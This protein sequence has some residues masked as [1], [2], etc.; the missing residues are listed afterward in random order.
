MH[1]INGHLEWTKG[2]LTFYKALPKEENEE[3]LAR[4]VKIEDYRRAFKT[5]D[6]S[7]ITPAQ[8]DQ[9]LLASPDE[10]ILREE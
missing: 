5:V 9:L 2:T 3:S 6:K 7:Y 1:S 10:E 4:Y 8:H